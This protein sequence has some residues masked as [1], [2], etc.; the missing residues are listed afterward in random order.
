MDALSVSDD[1]T[2][3]SVPAR[4]FGTKTLAL[5]ALSLTFAHACGLTTSGE[6]FCWGVNT[7]GQLGNGSK[8]ETVR[9]TLVSPQP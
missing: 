9:P 3:E 6:I 5:K 4:I 7:Y 2:P 8:E 1:E